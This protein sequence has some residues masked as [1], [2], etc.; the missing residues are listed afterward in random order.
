MANMNGEGRA[1]TTLGHNLAAR[2][3][4]INQACRE[5]AAM[6][7][8]IREKQQA[9]AEYKNRVI[10]GDL[11]FKMADFNMAY[12]LY[13]L[14]GRDRDELLDTIRETFEALGQGEQ[15]DWLKVSERAASKG[16]SD[17]TEPGAVHTP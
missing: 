13:G 15:L 4:L 1:D 14:E 2:R 5:L 10:K 17:A 11:G 12:R 16:K 3:D 8:D 6:D 9:R 7:A